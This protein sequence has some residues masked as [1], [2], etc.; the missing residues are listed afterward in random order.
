[1]DLALAQRETLDYL[2]RSQYLLLE[3]LQAKSPTRPLH[4]LTKDRIKKIV[5]REKISK[6]S[7][8]RSQ[9]WPKPKCSVTRM[10]CFFW[11]LIQLSLK[12]QKLS[13]RVSGNHRGSPAFTEN[14]IW[15]KRNYKQ[16]RSKVK[17][18]NKTLILY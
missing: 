2:E 5:N 8:G 4:L 11:S 15:S 1:V 9:W 10:K 17:N 13:S 16:V 6:Q 14:I 12:F 3:L 18:R 7:A